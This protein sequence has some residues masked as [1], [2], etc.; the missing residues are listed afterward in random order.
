[1]IDTRSSAGVSLVDQFRQPGRSFEGFGFESSC[2]LSRKRAFGKDLSGEVEDMSI[3]ESGIR[4]RIPGDGD[5][6]QTGTDDICGQKYQEI[7][8]AALSEN[9]NSGF[10]IQASEGEIIEQKVESCEPKE[11]YAVEKDYVQ[12]PESD[13][14]SDEQSDDDNF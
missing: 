5:E 4:I 14:L 12:S 8:R 1:M 13:E 9:E 10:R 7:C 3:A 2:R 6:V 11:H